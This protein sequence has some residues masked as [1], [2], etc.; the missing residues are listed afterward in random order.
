L[1]A[2]QVLEIPHRYKIDVE[3]LAIAPSPE[4]GREDNH[5]MRVR[6]AMADCRREAEAMGVP[7][8]RAEPPSA[9]AV[10]E[11]LAATEAARTL[12]DPGNFVITAGAAIWGEGLDFADPGTLRRVC[13][14]VGVSHEAV[15]RAKM[16]GGHR[17]VCDANAQLLAKLGH[18]DSAVAELDRELFA[19]HSRFEMLTERLDRMGL[20]R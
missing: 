16:G 11:A 13:E 17:K 19:T 1:Y 9:E 3:W 6:Y 12:T 14:Q 4:A 15:D 10:D 20:G 8:K 2:L 5:E 7:F 18:W